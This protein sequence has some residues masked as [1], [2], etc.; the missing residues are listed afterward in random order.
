MKVTVKSFDVAMEVKT[1]GIEFEIDSPDGEIH[2]GDL[3]LTKTSLV[4]CK[5]KTTPA[6]GIKIKWD[7]FMAWTDTQSPKK[8]GN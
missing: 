2:Y 8:K 1:K 3:V 6:K 7:D 5:G 4:W